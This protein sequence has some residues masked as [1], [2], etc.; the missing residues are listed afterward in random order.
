MKAVVT[1]N[2]EYEEADVMKLPQLVGDELAL[3]GLWEGE[4]SCQVR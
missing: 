4:S 3:I 2:A 1:C